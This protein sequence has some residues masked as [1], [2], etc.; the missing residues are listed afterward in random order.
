[1]K[2]NP[3]TSG[4]TNIGAGAAAKAYRN[5]D[6]VEIITTKNANGFYDASR[7]I[8]I[9]VR[10]KLPDNLKKY[11]PNIERIRIDNNGR[12]DI[13]FI[14]L[15]KFYQVPSKKSDIKNIEFPSNDEISIIEREFQKE[16]NRAY[17][18]SVNGIEAKFDSKYEED[19]AGI[20]DCPLFNLA[21]ENGHII[22]RDPVVAWMDPSDLARIYWDYR[23]SDIADMDRVGALTFLSRLISVTLS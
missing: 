4:F 10:K 14:Y 8:V 20:K 23:I 7:D 19:D 1:M 9:E 17:D 6:K 22:Y 18:K 2:R 11:L 15:M 5:S 3:P 13:E 16:F 21:I 12:G